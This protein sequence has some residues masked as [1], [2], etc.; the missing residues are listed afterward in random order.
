MHPDKLRRTLAAAL[1]ATCLTSL[2]MYAAKRR[3]VRSPS[4]GSL[5]VTGVVTDS[6]TGAPVINAKVFVD[7]RHTDSTDENGAYEI[8]NVPFATS[9]TILTAERTGYITKTSTLASGT[10]L[11]FSLVATPTVTVRKTDNTTFT[12]DQESI[13]F[14]YPIAFSGYREDESEDFCRPDG[15][16]IVVHRSE[17]RKITG[18][19]AVATSAA[20]CP[21]IDSRRVRVELKTGEITDLFFVDACNGFPNI[22][23]KGR[24]HVT[25]A[26]I[27]TPFAEIAE[28]TFP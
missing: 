14:G 2:P 4:A 22:D 6:A 10:T 27:Y 3:S 17:I 19:A 28:I 18:P 24:N 9:G 5:T 11:N 8:R 20:C 16:Q 12:L 26:T 13:M 21:G 1:L 25:G 7:A 15:T 23:V